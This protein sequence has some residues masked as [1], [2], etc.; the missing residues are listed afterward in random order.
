MTAEGLIALDA[1]PYSVYINT[2]RRQSDEAVSR[3]G[4]AAVP[5]H[6]VIVAA[7]PG[8]IS[9]HASTVVRHSSR[10][11]PSTGR[12]RAPRRRLCAST[13]GIRRSAVARGPPATTK[14]TNRRCRTQCDEDEIVLPPARGRRRLFQPRQSGDPAGRR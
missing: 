10:T 1:I 14:L 9:P 7:S 4:A 5:E 12:L 13:P 6:P 11:P 3:T 8:A 2:Q